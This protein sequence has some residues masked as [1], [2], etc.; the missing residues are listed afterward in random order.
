MCLFGE[1]RGVQRCLDLAW[2]NAEGRDSYD[3]DVNAL[4]L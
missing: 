3:L 2:M 1:S 4:P